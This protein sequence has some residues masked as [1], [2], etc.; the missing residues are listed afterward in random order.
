[1]I[2]EKTQ[3]FMKK[4]TALMVLMEKFRNVMKNPNGFH[5]K[6]IGFCNRNHGNPLRFEYVE[7]FDGKSATEAFR[8][9]TRVFAGRS[10][11]WK[12]HK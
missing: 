7:K 3:I 4:P 11:G 1:M 9:G 8:M 6:T 5:G 2:S 12:N 10:V